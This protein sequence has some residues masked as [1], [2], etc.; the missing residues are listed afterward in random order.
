MKK[1]F[2]ISFFSVLLLSCNDK[3]ID[4][5]KE[6]F[7]YGSIVTRLSDIPAGNDYFVAGSWDGSITASFS[8]GDEIAI[9]NVASRSF[10]VYTA[11]T[12]GSSSVRF[13]P[14]SLSSLS[15]SGFYMGAFPAQAMETQGS[16]LGVRFPALQQQS[17]AG[18]SSHVGIN[19]VL[20]SSKIDFANN[21]LNLNFAHASALLQIELVNTGSDANV[22]V[23]KISIAD[24]DAGKRSFLSFH[25]PRTMDVFEYST[26]VTLSVSS[27]S[28]LSASPSNYWMTVGANAA[29]ADNK[30]AFYVYTN[31]GTK[32]FE[33]TLPASGLVAGV[34]YTVAI[35][36]TETDETINAAIVE[37][38]T[39]PEDNATIDLSVVDEYVF[40]W[41]AAD[42]VTSP[43]YYTLLFD[44]IDGDFSTPIAV[45]PSDDDGLDAKLTLSKSEMN[46][47]AGAAGALALESA[48]VKWAVTATMGGD[49]NL[50]EE[51]RNVTI[52]R[53]EDTE[54]A[55]GHPLY[56][57][58]DGAENGQP[59]KYLG[60]GVYEIF[61]R[62][63]A[64]Q[65]FYFSNVQSFEQQSDMPV[66]FSTNVAG[67]SFGE[68]LG[69]ALASGRVNIS[70]PYRIRLNF[71]TWTATINRIDRIVL[72]NCNLPGVDVDMTYMGQGAWMTRN[73]NVRMSTPNFSPNGEERY[74]FLFAFDGAN[75]T[76]ATVEHWGRIDPSDAR[77]SI[78]RE[79]YR[80]IQ[81]VGFGVGQWLGAFKFPQE[82]VDLDNLNRYF[83]DVILYMN[84]EHPNYTHE[85]VNYYDGT[86][87]PPKIRDINWHEAA[88]SLTFVLVDQFMNKDRGVFWNSAR[89]I[90][91]NSATM[92]WQQAYP[93][94]TLLFS[95]ER[96]KDSDPAL[97][98]QYRTYFD[99]WVA[100]DGNN[101]YNVNRRRNGF[102]NEF[103][104]DM[105]WMALV[106][107]HMYEVT[108]NQARFD[109]AVEIYDYM[110]EPERIIDD[111]EGWGLIWKLPI[112]G[113]QRNACT[114]NPAIIIGCLL[115][116]ATGEQRYLTE[117][118]KIFDFMTNSGRVRDDGGVTSIPL[119]YTQGTWI[120]ACRLLYHITGD[121][122][123]KD[124]ATVCIEYT[125]DPRGSCTTAF[126]I[127]R[128]EG[129]SADQANFK[130]GLIPYMVSYANDPQMPAATR[131]QVKDFLKF[132]AQTLWLQGLDHSQFPRMF[133]NFIWNQI[134]V[135][136]VGVPNS[137]NNYR[138]GQV[139]AHNSGAALI[140]GMTRLVDF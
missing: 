43:V 115:H 54:F 62:L 118:I 46:M 86:L 55:V 102:Y 36:W 123:Y 82:L 87:D 30:V 20:T 98:A 59:F 132:N 120:E 53:P 110:T 31:K 119:S 23:E 1:V 104:D 18:N 42:K 80:D 121:A 12:D 79:G 92:Y 135:Y 64:N 56:I 24:A 5:L 127:L 111:H 75:V 96:I 6:S 27:L 95:H 134:Y 69:V 37:N 40:S 116:Q 77:P 78:N 122:K 112:N 128:N 15:A 61:T 65:T 51:I 48:T 17:A 103:T 125:M 10:D 137:D 90:A 34:Q 73:Y 58:G 50:S 57:L 117:A 100:N 129:T 74:K 124:R 33:R 45:F 44:F 83:T 67:T 63:E 41:A 13:E 89:N 138:P 106:L 16:N 136:N 21:T 76:L 9:V 133:C 66:F 126:G 107:L 38:L 25:I 3:E 39:L 130:G 131:Q 84:T 105:A 49:E 88:D 32:R 60:D 2:I 14:A 139:G 35:D 22:Q 70:S 113:D 7:V 99:R 26:G 52:I 71:E 85:F 140:E 101:W 68:I 109:A 108:G 93:M 28:S 72:R 94:H 91:N 29:C 47:I 4:S 11:S 114:N 81:M 8:I 19:T 97:A